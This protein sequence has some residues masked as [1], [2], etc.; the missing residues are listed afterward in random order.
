MWG[1]HSPQFRQKHLAEFTDEDE[2]SF[3]PM[4]TVRACMDNP[5]A[6]S[7]G[8]GS[9]FIDWSTG[10]DETVIA[11]TEGNRLR[12]VAAFRERDPVQGVRRVAAIL[13][14]HSL[15]T[16]VC[17]RCWRWRP[18]DRAAGRTWDLRDSGSQRQPCPEET[19]SPVRA[20]S[21]P[22]RL[23]MEFPGGS[24]FCSYLASRRPAPRRFL[25]QRSLC[26]GS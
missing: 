9:T 26:E 21:R 18:N 3:I 8:S 15:L 19:S 25:V 10:G 20:V 13:R 5:P 6:F 17:G 16:S 14:K 23:H 4:E 24:S 2:E 7:A 11:S 22:H 1:E 12:I